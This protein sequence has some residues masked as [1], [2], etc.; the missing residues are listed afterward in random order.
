PFD[1]PI[2]VR[3]IRLAAASRQPRQTAST[4]ARAAPATAPGGWE[5]RVASAGNPGR[6]LRG[7]VRDRL[8][9]AAVGAGSGRARRRGDRTGLVAHGHRGT[10]RLAAGA[11]AR[12]AGDAP[13]PPAQR[14]GPGTAVANAVAG[15]LPASPRRGIMS[16]F[17]T[18]PGT[19]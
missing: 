4:C 9:G 6:G 16:C 12:G 1:G 2:A 17:P 8:R 18:A 11:R 10:R 19:A 14:G 13:P 3:W 15:P 7:G 5:H